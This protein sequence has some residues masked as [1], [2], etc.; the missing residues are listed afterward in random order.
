MCRPKLSTV[1]RRVCLVLGLHRKFI[2]STNSPPQLRSSLI[3]VSYSNELST[4][5]IDNIIELGD[6]HV[7][8]RIGGSSGNL[9]H[10]DPD[11]DVGILPTY[12]A[13]ADKPN[14]LKIGPSIVEGF[15][16]WPNNTKYIFGIDFNFNTFDNL[17]QT[18]LPLAPIV[19]DA[20]G[21]QLE[22]FEIGNE[23]GR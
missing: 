1:L 3:F 9:L 17:I 20:L 23:F 13:G 10:W 18:D 2:V 14:Y 6:S 22:A 19:F 4:N 5:L 12:L 8:L 16:V 11:L 21:N 7:E 15:Q